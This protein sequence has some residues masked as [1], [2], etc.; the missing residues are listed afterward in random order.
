MRRSLSPL[1][2]NALPQG[3]TPILLLRTFGLV[4]LLVLSCVGGGAMALL[5]RGM[6]FRLINIVVYA[7]HFDQTGATHLFCFGELNLC[8]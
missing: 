8:T 7:E 2:L 4:L 6:S 5:A 1:P 3:D